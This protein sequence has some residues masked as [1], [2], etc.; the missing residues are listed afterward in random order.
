MECRSSLLPLRVLRQQAVRLHSQLAKNLG[1]SICRTIIQNN[2]FK[3]WIILCE[4]GLHTAADVAFFITRRDTNR[5]H[6]RIRGWRGWLDNNI[7]VILIVQPINDNHA[8]HEEGCG[9]D[10][11]GHV[12]S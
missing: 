3:I 6:W 1:S 8:S 11:I 9:E 4:Q 7:K 2:D 12:E 10:Q 5:D